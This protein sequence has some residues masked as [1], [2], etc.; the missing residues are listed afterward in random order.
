GGYTDSRSI[1]LSLTRPAATTVLPPP[2]PPLHRNTTGITYTTTFIFLLFRLDLHNK[3]GVF[4]WAAGRQP[5]LNGCL[6]RG[7]G[8]RG[9][10]HLGTFVW[11]PSSRLRG[12][13]VG[14]PKQHRACLFG[15]RGSK[16]RGVFVG[17]AETSMPPKECLFR[18]PR[19]QPP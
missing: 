18:L 5:Q 15:C 11:L 7:H 16:L 8:C 17:A 14:L 2:L 19:Q 10:S 9:S 1:P 12:R 6:F 4:A 13:L 3:K